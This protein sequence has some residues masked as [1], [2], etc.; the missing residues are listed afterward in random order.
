MLYVRQWHFRFNPYVCQLKEKHLAA[1]KLNVA[2]VD[3]EEAF[4]CVP[5]E[6]IW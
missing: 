6:S 1:K 5:G 4:D 3:L 2:F